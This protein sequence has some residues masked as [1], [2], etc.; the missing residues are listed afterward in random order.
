MVPGN[1]P[2]DRGVWGQGQAEEGGTGGGVLEEE[3]TLKV[4][5]YIKKYLKK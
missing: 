1:T 4:N 2:R 5:I 3:L